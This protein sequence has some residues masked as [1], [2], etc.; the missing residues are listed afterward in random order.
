MSK[1]NTW[2]LVACALA[3]GIT[4]GA[5]HAA[6]I[7]HWNFEEQTGQDIANDA[8]ASLTLRRGTSGSGWG[9]PA[10]SAGG[11]NGTGG[12]HYNSGAPGANPDYHVS[13]AKV[14]AEAAQ[15]SLTSYTAEI[16]FKLDNIPPTGFSRTKPYSLLSQYDTT[17]NKL[18]YLLRISGKSNGKGQ[19][20]VYYDKAAGGGQ[21]LNSSIEL[22]ANVWYYAAISRAADGTQKL[23]VADVS[24]LDNI[25][26]TTNS[27]SGTGAPFSG[28]GKFALGAQGTSSSFQ[29]GFVGIID[30]VRISDEVLDE[31]ALLVN[32]IPEPA[33]LLLFGVG[34]LV[35][36]SRKR[37]L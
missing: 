1:M 35:L 23:M 4:T 25:S 28:A 10:W 5:T 17:N 24:D 37:H 2:R 26:I 9:D 3:L 20:N 18:N 36:V 22:D 32:N 34:G 30:N 15:L 7:A 21:S 12:L 19:L 16:F 8:G 29:R 6:T 11:F 14:T 33:S 27:A 31:S 13:T